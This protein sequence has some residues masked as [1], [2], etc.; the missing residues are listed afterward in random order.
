MHIQEQSDYFTKMI[1]SDSC[2]QRKLSTAT[3]FNSF[4]VDICRYLSPADKVTFVLNL[5]NGAEDVAQ[6]YEKQFVYDWDTKLLGK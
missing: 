6:I 4:T 1:S 5:L 3:L 2:Q